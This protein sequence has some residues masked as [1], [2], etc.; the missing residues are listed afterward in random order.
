MALLNLLHTLKGSIAQLVKAI[1]S[2]LITSLHV[3]FSSMCFQFILG[4]L[5]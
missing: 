2:W 1:L 5:Y 4:R 3:S